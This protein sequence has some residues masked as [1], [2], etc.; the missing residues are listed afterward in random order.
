MTDTWEYVTRFT[1]TIRSFYDGQMDMLR[2]KYFHN[3]NGY[4]SSIYL[5]NLVNP[6]NKVDVKLVTATIKDADIIDL[7]P[8]DIKDPVEA[9]VRSYNDIDDELQNSSSVSLLYRQNSRQVYSTLVNPFNRPQMQR[10]LWGGIAKMA[11][12]AAMMV[13]GIVMSCM[14]ADKARAEQSKLKCA[15]NASYGAMLKEI[16]QSYDLV[17]KIISDAVVLFD[18][19]FDIQRTNAHQVYH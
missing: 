18:K 12:G 9:L 13:G 19:E 17:N 3:V 2:S 8:S 10:G 4:L 5:P 1:D 11:I 14:I 16:K 6:T 15:A 7:E